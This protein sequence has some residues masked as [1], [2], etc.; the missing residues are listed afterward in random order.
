MV[1]AVRAQTD[2]RISGVVVDGA[3]NPIVNAR[4]ILTTDVGRMETQTDVTGTFV[5]EASPS[6]AVSIEVIADGFAP[7]TVAVPASDGRINITLDPRPVEEEV[8][9]LRTKTRLDE[10]PVSAVALNS[11]ELETSAALTIDDRLRQIPGFSLFR[12][13]GSRSANPTT[14]GVSLRGIGASGASRAI[15]LADG[16]PLNDPFGGWVYW[17]RVPSESISQVEV[18]RGPAGDL[19]GSSAIGGVVSIV[20]RRPTIDPFVSLDTSYGTQRTPAGSFFASA[21]M[22]RWA[23]SIAGEI[24][25][26]N[27]FMPVAAEQRGRVDTNAGVRR[28][29]FIPAIAHTF[30]SGSRI[31]ASAEFFQEQRTNGTPL[32]YNNTN[33]RN[34]AGGTDLDLQRAGVIAFR[35]HAGTQGYNQSFTAIA[36]DRHS[37]S[38]T[39]LQ[40]VPSR[41]IGG[42]GQWNV[43]IRR[44]VLF[45]GFDFRYVRGRSDEIGFANGSATSQSS[46]GGRESTAGVYIGGNVSITDRLLIAGA[47]RY[48]GWKNQRGFSVTRSLVSGAVTRSDFPDRSESAFSPRFAALYRLTDNVSIAGTISTGFRRPTLNELYRNFRVGDVLTLANAALVAERATGFD[49]AVIA[50][51]FHQRLFFRSSIFC[52]T[53][54]RNVSNVTLTV[55]PSLIT[56]QRQNIGRTRSCGIESDGEFKLSGQ[57]RLSG[58]YL[59]VDSRVTSFPANTA[60]EG[61]R[62][63]QIPGHQ[64]TFQAEYSNTRIATIAMQFRSASSQF[65]DDQNQ[66]R[67]SSFALVDVFGSRRLTNNIAVFAAVENLSGTRVESGRTP[68]LTLSSPRTLRIGL[69]MRFGKGR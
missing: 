50:N 18:L 53:V 61:L 6:K 49:G 58:G 67:L 22:S 51:G 60:L 21:G 26:T 43:N 64:F 42:S 37:E 4:V 15:V 47:V 35:I 40:H 32:Q 2:N 28:S 1:F 59:F 33:L 38:L 45:A 13:A 17:G 56:R 39:R 68:V 34:F 63:P 3:D 20:T 24:L 12:R 65:D 57:V 19:Y 23:G 30:T 52:T 62:V 44:S 41:F 46:A 5:F 10:T 16:V 36:A 27:G 54:S 7:R 55:T 69:R 25:R 29:V 8:M 11:H 48:D 14:Q 66:F 31:F 9:I